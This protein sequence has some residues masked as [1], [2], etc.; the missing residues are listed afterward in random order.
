MSAPEVM[1]AVVAAEGKTAKVA[2]NVTVPT[3][4]KG[5]ILVKVEAITLNPTE[6]VSYSKHFEEER[7]R[8]AWGKLT[9]D[10]N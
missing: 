10:S 8:S 7:G 6:W 5:E 4:A 1:K 3:L 9:I 2:S